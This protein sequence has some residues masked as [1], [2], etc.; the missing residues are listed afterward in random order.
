M[1]VDRH[2]HQT[3]PGGFSSGAELMNDSSGPTLCKGVGVKVSILPPN[4]TR[5]FSPNQVGNAS[6]SQKANR[7][8]DKES[9]ESALPLLSLMTRASC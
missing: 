4:R 8:V 6:N 2:Q 5:I 7:M 1:A 9:V 3:S